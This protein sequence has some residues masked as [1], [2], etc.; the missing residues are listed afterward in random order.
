[1]K[2]RVPGIPQ[3]IIGGGS[4]A[5]SA[6]H[7]GLDGTSQAECNAVISGPLKVEGKDRVPGNS[8][9]KNRGSIANVRAIEKESS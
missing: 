7:L 3:K 9:S 6:Y 8:K 2:R 4:G 5:Q 1:M